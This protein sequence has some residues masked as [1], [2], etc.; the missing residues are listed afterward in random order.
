MAT[1]QLLWAYLGP[2]TTLPLVSVLGAAVGVLLMFWHFLFGL[3]R[4][5][6]RKLFKIGNSGT[7]TGAASCPPIPIVPGVEGTGLLGDA[8]VNQSPPMGLSAR[9][10]E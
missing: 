7:A 3:L 1:P 5:I 8:G 9:S 2:E 4:R 6:F 10:S